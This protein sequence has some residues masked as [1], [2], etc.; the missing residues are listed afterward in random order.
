MRKR[1]Y[2]SMSE[3]EKIILENQELILLGLSK[4]LTPLCKGN[5]VDANNE[6][7]TNIALIKA[8]HDTRIYLGKESYE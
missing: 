2:V 5:F 3:T 4:L 7:Q 6:T 1:T 8:Y